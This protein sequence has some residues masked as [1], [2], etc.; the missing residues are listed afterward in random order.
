MSYTITN[1]VMYVRNEAG[2]LV[3]VSMIA[4]E[5]DQT[6]AAIN[7]AA[8]NAMA[9]VEAKVDE[10][11]ARIPEVTSVVSEVDQINDDISNYA[12]ISYVNE[13]IGGIENGSY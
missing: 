12:T 7:T 4:S 6:I 11:L 5:A 2:E 1:N 8:I 3:P 9:A 10:Q 13:L